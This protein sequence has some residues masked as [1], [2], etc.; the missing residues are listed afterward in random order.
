MQNLAG[1]HP[2]LMRLL[3]DTNLNVDTVKFK[4]SALIIAIF[5]L[6]IVYI[7]VFNEALNFIR[8]HG[9]FDC[10]ITYCIFMQ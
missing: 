7:I 1:Q 4:I 9:Y 3:N 10:T 8:G 5:F 2:V 6:Y